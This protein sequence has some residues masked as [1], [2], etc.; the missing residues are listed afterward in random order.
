VIF[1]KGR[2]SGVVFTKNESEWM[3]IPFSDANG[4]A[5]HGSVMSAVVCTFK[6]KMFIVTLEAWFDTHSGTGWY[7]SVPRTSRHERGVNCGGKPIGNFGLTSL[8]WPLLGKL[9]VCCFGL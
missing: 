2:V 9:L 4:D 6:K 7:H 5:C 8:T 1:R 3:F